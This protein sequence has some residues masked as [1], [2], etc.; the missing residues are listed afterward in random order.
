MGAENGEV[1]SVVFERLEDLLGGVSFD[2]QERKLE[3]STPKTEEMSW[4]AAPAPV[5]APVVPQQ[6]APTQQNVS[7]AVPQGVTA[8]AY[9]MPPKFQTPSM[10]RTAAQAAAARKED[11]EMD[12]FEQ[13]ELMVAT[14]VVVEQPPAV[15]TAPVQH[16]APQQSTMRGSVYNDAFIPPAPVDPGV[17]ETVYGHGPQFAPGLHATRPVMEPAQP[18]QGLVLRPPVPGTAAVQ[19]KKKT[20]S[21]FER[22]AGPLRHH[23][24][25]GRGDE[26]T[27]RTEQGSAGAG[28]GLR[29]AQHPVQP[30]GNL[31]I[32]APVAGKA[33]AVADDELDIPAFLRRQ[34][35]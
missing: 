12:M 1:V 21:L 4:Q 14:T 27:G 29:A 30:Q 6:A 33:G 9:T 34:A 10:P 5:S 16:A 24:E 25:Q 35:N 28:G 2:D 15:E 18:T 26:D 8:A 11:P 17:N 22:F 3:R 23:G 20:P 7:A 31:A 19:Q 13:Q 32:D